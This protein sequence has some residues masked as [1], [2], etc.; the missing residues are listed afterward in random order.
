[1]SS[2]SP[3]ATRL[4]NKSRAAGVTTNA[5]RI[6]SH[7]HKGQELVHAVR[8]SLDRTQMQV[9]DNLVKLSPGWPSLLR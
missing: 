9:E 4:S 8:L 1:M 2:F 6:K 5:D 7:R 3:T